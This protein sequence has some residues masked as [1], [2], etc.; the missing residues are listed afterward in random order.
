MWTTHTFRNNAPLP[1]PWS[2]SDIS[3]FHNTNNDKISSTSRA[4]LLFYL[5]QALWPSSTKS[6]TYVYYHVLPWPLFI[7][8][9]CSACSRLNLECIPLLWRFSY[10]VFHREP[11]F[12]GHGFSLLC[13][14]AWHNN[15]V[16]ANAFLSFH[17]ASKHMP[18]RIDILTVSTYTGEVSW[19]VHFARNL[20]SVVNQYT[21]TCTSV[22][23]T[24]HRISSRLTPRGK[25]QQL[26]HFLSAIVEIF[27]NISVV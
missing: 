2:Y 16:F 12:T 1:D 7:C 21:E 5:L 18:W 20:I 6:D 23:Q 22:P 8:L 25:L 27:L 4:H 9:Y 3:T 11:Y 15:L 17:F 13:I 14:V 24:Y 10:M 26:L 19:H